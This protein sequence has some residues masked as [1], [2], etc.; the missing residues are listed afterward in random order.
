MVPVDYRVDI[1]SSRIC[2]GKV[3][4]E[5]ISRKESWAVELSS[6]GGPEQEEKIFPVVRSA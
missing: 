4:P 2:N 6:P 3:L 5:S 1:K